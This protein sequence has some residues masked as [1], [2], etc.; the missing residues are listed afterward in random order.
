Y[1]VGENGKTV[2][3]A[4]Y[5]QST[6]PRPFIDFRNAYP[7]VNAW[8]MPPVT[9]NGA[10]NAFIPVTTLRQGLIDTSTPPDLSRGILKLPANSGTT[11]YP[12][13]EMRKYIQSW[14]LIVERELNRRMTASVGYVGTRAV[15]Q[16]G[17]ININASAPGTGT[18]GRPLFQKFG[19]TQDINEIIP[20][21]TTT[22]DALQSEFRGRFG[23]SIVGAAYTW[24]KAINFA[25]N[26]ANP[27]IQ[28]QPEADRNRGPASY[29]RTHNFQAYTVYDLPF[30]KGRRLLSDGFGGYLLG[31]WQVNGILSLMSSTPFY[32]VQN[33]APNL[34]AGGSG[35]VPNQIK[36]VVAIN[37]DNLKGL[38]PGGAAGAAAP[39]YRYFDTTAF[40]P[41]NGA[42]FGN[43]GR[44][45]LRGPGFVNLDLSLF[46]SFSVTERVRLQF[47]GEFLNALNHPNFSNPGSN[48]SDAG[49]FGFITSTTGTGERN[50]RL[51]ARVAF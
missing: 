40:A 37:G 22:Y 10:T 4:G 25:D 27:R 30:G 43:V 28:Y 23:N 42:R 13:T 49:T 50:I 35:Q 39:G 5:G 11:T 6:D 14:N 26:D 31:G 9:F 36:P 3:R 19:I 46:R 32:I 24:S 41:E 17:F 45:T 18:A 8:A 15:G 1:R 44:N 2:V 7:I 51:S 16:M 29:D 48:I 21:K 12:D 38:P 34:L 47:R 20:Y 33:T